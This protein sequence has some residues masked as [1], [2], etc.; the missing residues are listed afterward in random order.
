MVSMGFNMEPENDG[1]SRRNLLFSMLLIF[2]VSMLNSRGVNIYIYTH[3]D[4][5]YSIIRTCFGI[6]KA[7]VMC[8]FSGKSEHLW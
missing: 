7:N 1:N 5:T 6:S 3:I 4:R 8:F 2:Q